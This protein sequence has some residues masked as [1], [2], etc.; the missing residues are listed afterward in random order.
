MN[1][2][3]NLKLQ[4]PEWPD[5]RE[6]GKDI[7][8]HMQNATLPATREE[9][10]T[11]ASIENLTKAML[12]IATNA[13]RIRAKLSD[14]ATREPRKE[15]GKDELRKIHR[16][17]EAM[18]ESFAGIGMEVKDRTG[19]IFDYGLPEKVIDAQ[20]RVGVSKE[21][22]IETIRPTIYLRHHIAQQ[23]EIII[24]TPF[25]ASDKKDI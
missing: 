11:T 23:G 12:A 4:R 3:D 7:A 21:M 6:L 17:V 22:V 18:F 9:S 8:E 14:S 15:I 25:D 5:A 2:P 16:Y 20:P 13:W 19:D 10:T 24:A 1:I